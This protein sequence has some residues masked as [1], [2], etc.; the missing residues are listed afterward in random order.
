MSVVI[1]FLRVA[2]FSQFSRGRQDMLSGF[3]AWL[4]TN[5]PDADVEAELSGT[6]SALQSL[7]Q[8]EQLN[9]DQSGKSS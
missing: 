8:M 7:Q 5:P 3:T 9:A 6:I 4:K 2:P 1:P